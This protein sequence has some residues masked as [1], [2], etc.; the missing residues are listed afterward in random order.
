MRLS[1]APR[2]SAAWIVPPLN[3]TLSA[4]TSPALQPELG[5]TMLQVA[6]CHRG[7]WKP[8][9]RGPL[10]WQP[11]FQSHIHT[12]NY[13]QQ[14]CTLYT[15]NSQMSHCTK[16]HKYPLLLGPLCSTCSWCFEQF[17]WHLRERESWRETAAGGWGRQTLVWPFTPEGTLQHTQ[18]CPTPSG[19]EQQGSEGVIPCCGLSPLSFVDQHMA[20]SL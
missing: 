10:I 12:E 4:E 5:G 8:H 9:G 7:M 15:A 6:E 19:A 13:S 16:T 18:S 14:D 20:S 3:S 11:S 2:Y 1:S 17:S